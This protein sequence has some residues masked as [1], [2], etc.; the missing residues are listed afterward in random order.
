V[1]PPAWLS[2]VH[3][4][5]IVVGV[6]VLAFWATRAEGVVWSASTALAAVGGALLAHLAAALYAFRFRLV[7]RVVGIHLGAVESLRLNWLATFYQFFVPFAV[8]ADVTRMVKL[9]VQNH[10]TL[11]SV[12]GIVLD[13]LVGLLA[14][15]VLVGVLFVSQRPQGLDFALDADP[16][17]LGLGVFL[18]VAG[19]IAACWRYRDRAR[20]LLDTLLRHR[21]ALVLGL[22]F[23]VAMQ[24]LLACA[25][26]AASVAWD[27]G[28]AYGDVLFVLSCAQFLQGVPL[29]I[30]GAGIA[31]VAGAGLFVALGLTLPAAI[32]LMSLFYLCRLSVAMTGGL[33]ELWAVR[34]ARL[35]AQTGNQA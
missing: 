19:G 29:Q 35:P 11:P 14:L 25:I 16:G 30:A 5:A 15:I 4:G 24:M 2:A 23:S 20:A 12:S 34:Q 28:L 18:V 7:M 27:L 21:R 3:V 31:D 22:L 17:L 26:W 1:R 10:Q 33:W 6:P 32:L 9:K 8:G 13:H